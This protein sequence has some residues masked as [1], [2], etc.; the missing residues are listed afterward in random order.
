M[1][2][3]ARPLPIP[4]QRARATHARRQLDLYTA[5]AR[6][7]DRIQMMLAR[8]IAVDL[9]EIVFDVVRW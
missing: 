1:R 2:G 5:V 8:Q 6:Q 3:E 9:L 7:V 4:P